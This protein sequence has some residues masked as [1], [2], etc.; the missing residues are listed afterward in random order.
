MADYFR[1]FKEDIDNIEIPEKELNIV[2]SQAVNR[3]TL[4]KFPYS[5]LKKTGSIVIALTFLV[6]GSGFVSPAMA[7]LLS[8]IPYIDYI[9][10]YSD[11]G[12]KAAFE[13]GHVKR[14]GETEIDEGIPLTITDVYYDDSRLEIG[15]LIPLENIKLGN[16]RDIKI[17]G[18]ANAKILLNGEEAGYQSGGNY[19]KEK[20]TGTMT[21]IPDSN[22]LPDVAEIKLQVTE[23]LN[24]KGQWLFE[25]PIKKVSEKEIFKIEKRVETNE[26]VFAAN[27]IAYT[28]SAT[29]IDYEFEK[30]ISNFNPHSIHFYLYNEKGEKLQLIR[31]GI[32]EFQ[33]SNNSTHFKSELFFE[34]I[35]NQSEKLTIVPVLKSG[36][37]VEV[38]LKELSL[39]LK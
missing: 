5:P 31:T 33:E 17:L 26:Y 32:I 12:L 16:L 36:E 21:V 23:V 9:L 13:K 34:P 3:G 11:I 4:K 37:K 38:V 30:K 39:E 25:I 29:K 7:N 35:S 10:P 24:K 6:F 15:Y 28:P 18:I 14:I 8:N 19:S 22:K 2:I 20:I 1:K 27:K